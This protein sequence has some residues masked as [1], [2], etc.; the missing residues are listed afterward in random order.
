MYVDPGRQCFADSDEWQR[1]Q[2][3]EDLLKFAPVMP[4]STIGGSLAMLVCLWP[5]LPGTLLAAWCPAAVLLALAQWQSMVPAC[6]GTAGQW[7]RGLIASVLGGGVFWGITSIALFP[8]GSVE[9]QLLAAFILAAVTALWLPLFA[10]AR[11][12]LFVFA[13][14]AL[15]PMAFGLLTS[16][17][18]SQTTMGSLLL[19][20]TG[21]LAA[22]AHAT[23]RMFYADC[24]VRRALYHDATHDALVGL[25]NHAEFH[26]RAQALDA[27]QAQP[28]AM[29]FVDLD[30]F[31]EVNDAAGHAA[32]D[33]MLR[34]IGAILR[35]GIRKGDTAARLG[36]DEFAILMKDCG[37]QEAARVAAAILECI[38]G[39]RLTCDT[40]T[41]RVTASIGVACSTAVQASP[42]TI[43]AAADRACYTAKRAGRSRVEVAAAPERCGSTAQPAQSHRSSDFALLAHSST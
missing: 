22:V 9:H 15:L 5:V 28:Y 4:L 2:T 11:V 21:A 25:A 17:Q 42:T 43:L 38:N 14:P 23:R 36:G 31:K 34:Q 30:H 40:G 33:E 27:E 26:R 1:A 37:E 32:G 16:P 8:A 24:A 20:L 29:L 18:V 19:L 10:L 39:F 12:T 3:L 41:Y 35:Q 7:R 13:V 6:D